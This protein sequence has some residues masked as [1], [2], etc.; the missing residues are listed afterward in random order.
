MSLLYKNKRIL[1][2]NPEN[3]YNAAKPIDAE[4][5]LLKDS[6]Q[7]RDERIAYLEKAVSEMAEGEEIELR[8]ML[9]TMVDDLK[10]GKEKITDKLWKSAIKPHEFSDD[11]IK[12]MK[13]GGYFS[14]KLFKSQLQDRAIR[15]ELSRFTDE[16]NMAEFKRVAGPEYQEWIEA[17][18][19]LAKIALHFDQDLFNKM[20][21]LN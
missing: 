2:E 3:T 10:S 11:E 13:L 14:D 8:T 17:K 6:D 18:E 16:E 20:K 4:D 9:L 21:G 12:Y 15:A 7:L 1:P 5:V 19:Y